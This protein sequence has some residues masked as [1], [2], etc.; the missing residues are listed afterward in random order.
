MSQ[1]EEIKSKLDII[2]I[3]SEY[4]NLKPA[5][6]NFKAL[7]PFH[8]EKSPSFM[9]S[10][11]KQIWHCFGCSAGGDIFS[12]VQ[13]YEG[14]EFPEALRILANKAG[15]TLTKTNPQLHNQKTSLYDVCQTAANFFHQ[16]LLK[17][18]KAQKAL[19]YLKSR[20]VNQEFV[21]NF[22][23]GYSPDAWDVLYKYLKEK[24]FDDQQIFLAGLTV[25][26]DREYGYYDRFRNRLIFPIRD[27]H[28][29]VVGFTARALD[30]ERDKMGKYI[31][32][33]Q[34]LIYN[35]S[36]VIYGLDLAKADI[37]K[38]NLTVMVEGQMD[39]IASHQAGVKNVVATSGSAL[40]NEQVGFLKR[41]S[42]NIALAFDADL[43]G[44]AAAKRGI[45]VALTQGMNIKVI[46][47]PHGKD[48]DECIGENVDDWKQAIKNSS[49]YLDYYFKKVFEAFDVTN[50]E[51]KTKAA[52]YILREL[53]KVQDKVE[54]THYLQLL[55]EKINVSE[56][57]LRE[58]LN[59]ST[60]PQNIKT[61]KHENIKTSQTN[62]KGRFQDRN[63]LLSQR[64]L[65]LMLKYPEH[66]NYVSDHLEP[67]MLV[68]GWNDL[69]KNIIIYYTNKTEN[70][71]DFSYFLAK[72]GSNLVDE[73]DRLVLL[74]DKDYSSF[75]GSQIKKEIV[76]IAGQ[77]KKNNILKQ[78]K[79][80]ETRIKEMEKTADQSAI[81]SLTEEFDLLT[82]QLKSFA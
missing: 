81:G 16:L 73:A 61:L 39:V 80:L 68:E 59:K 43:A 12:F 10:R 24:K 76:A 75:D 27:L 45:D 38:E 37:K 31:N 79:E 19:D 70:Q 22:Q 11:E 44:E 41:Y 53:A 48:P 42:N 7:C 1:T 28:K 9:V 57:I 51:S 56:T 14:V 77:L 54:Q 78:L 67:Q 13:E 25:K 62:N 47:I 15:V 6:S 63:S 21:K 20:G 3:I 50:P 74:A 23:L 66:I 65:S 29:N 40:T 60:K 49:R 36:Q 52:K 8:N 72:A 55:S 64:L 26:K 18:P 32:T 69:Y 58:T 17:H 33:P 35:K 4:I 82:Q 34:T 2:D 30:E 5:G 71:Q 46:T